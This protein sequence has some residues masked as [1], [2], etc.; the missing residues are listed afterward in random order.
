MTLK[1]PSKWPS[2]P[3]GKIK[4][5]FEGLKAKMQKHSCEWRAPDM[6]LCRMSDH[7]DTSVTN[8]GTTQAYVI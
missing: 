6:L 2:T 3:F 8:D 1:H 5:I 7:D 4:I